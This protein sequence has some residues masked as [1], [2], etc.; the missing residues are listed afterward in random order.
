MFLWIVWCVGALGAAMFTAER[1][2]LPPAE[3]LGV[4]LMTFAGI[5]LVPWIISIV[6]D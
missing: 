6:R 4:G 1:V 2:N 3:A 5:T